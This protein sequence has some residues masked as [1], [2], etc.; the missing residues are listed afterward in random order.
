VAAQ[1]AGQYTLAEVAERSPDQLPPPLADQAVAAE[2]GTGFTVAVP[3]VGGVVVGFVAPYPAFEE[4]R[5]ELE[6]QA[7]GK[8]AEAAAPLIEDVRADLDVTVN[9]RF[10]VLE[11]G[12]L[13]PGGNDVVQLL[14]EDASAAGPDTGGN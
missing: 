9:P 11:D 3:E 5:P 8:A 2:P 1:Y 12:Q 6:Q 13:V 14:D 4:L 10:G 7:A